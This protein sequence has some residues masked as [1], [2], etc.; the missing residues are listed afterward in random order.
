[1]EK[2]AV[3]N[4]HNSEPQMESGSIIVIADDLTGAA[5]IA[6]VCL[7]YGLTVSF[8]IATVPIENAQVRIIATDSRSGKEEDAYALHHKIAH[9]LYRDHTPF[10]FKKCDSVL[11]GYVLGELSAILKVSGKK[12][13]LLQPANPHAGRFIKDGFY[14]IGEEKIQETSFSS[15][16]D[17]PAVD[18]MIQNILFQRSARHDCINVV[19]VGKITALKGSGVYVPDCSS[20]ADLQKC[21]GLSDDKTLLAG[22][23]AFFEQIL[24]QKGKTIQEKVI[25]KH[26][27]TSCFLIVSG[28]THAQS[29]RFAEKMQ[30]YNFPVARFPDALLDEKADPK[31]IDIWSELLCN[32][33]LEK[34][35]LVLTVSEKNV[36]FPGSSTILKQRMVQAVRKI[37]EQCEV[38]ELLIEGGAT[39]YAILEELSWFNLSP[40]EELS[41]GVVRMKVQVCTDVYLTLKPG[42][43]SWPENMI[44]SQ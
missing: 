36:S 25:S 38:K 28:S 5:E 6:G 39:A 11:R 15:D 35:A 30:S 24:I 1:M 4:N 29:R 21:S 10:I 27:I 40:V 31:L 37:V 8:G 14:Y 32:V 23:A 12:T 22:S 3:L 42:S 19:H 9:E 7:R 34:S 16:P 33:W 17:F 44:A 26:L 20:V 13:V 41:P 2:E 43:Y 18:S